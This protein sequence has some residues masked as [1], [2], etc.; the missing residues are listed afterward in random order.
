MRVHW[1]AVIV[2]T[3]VLG[4]PAAAIC[5]TT[6]QRPRGALID[7]GS[8]A[9][10]SWNGERMNRTAALER[11]IDPEDRPQLP[12]FRPKALELLE[13]AIVRKHPK[14]DKGSR[15]RARQHIVRLHAKKHGVNVLH[16]AMAEAL[17][18]EKN[19]EWGYVAKP[20]APY[21]D[22]YRWLPGRRA[23]VGGQVKFH[24]RLNPSA[25][26]NK[27][28]N[29]QLAQWFIIPDDHVQPMKDYLA[30]KARAAETAGN[31]GEAARLW[32]D[33]GRLRGVGATT[34]EIKAAVK[35]SVKIVV[36]EKAATYTSLGAA[37]ALSIG[38]EICDFGQGNATANVSLYRET[39]ALSTLGVAV[40][41]NRALLSIKD[42][43]LK[44]T[45]RG[46]LIVGTAISVADVTW[47]LYE[48]G[49]S[50][51]FYRPEFYEQV[52][53]DVSGI[54]LGLAIAPFVV[55]YPVFG[56]I[57]IIGTGIA[58]YV[59]GI[60]AAHMIIDIISPETIHRQERERIASV[61]GGLQ[62]SI[63]ALR[64]WKPAN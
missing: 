42:G 39:R 55:E 10:G 7:P 32:R 60:S 49:W 29:N 36:R 38:R 43:A 18:L 31:F 15:R 59:G 22:V 61:A 37:L 23:P 34:G 30:Q 53:G 46:N 20:N 13:D 51:A 41:A 25:Y 52:V 62:E 3:A 44:N 1:I 4:G 19:P 8:A 24:S 63:A 5:Q 21:H 50:Q 45:V 64:N 6:S 56:E 58:G 33:F 27:M 16:G 2:S 9:F 54:G 48:H 12:V 35:S 47:L 26:A 14:L 28:K 40:A 11:R 57:V 17:F